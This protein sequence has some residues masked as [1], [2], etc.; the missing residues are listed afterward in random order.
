MLLK[1]S[2]II[3]NAERARFTGPSSTSPRKESTLEALSETASRQDADPASGADAG[4]RGRDWLLGQRSTPTDLGVGVL[5]G[6]LV[7]LLALLFR[8]EIVPTDPWHYIHSAMGFPNHSWVPLGYT[9][10]GMVL[11]A[12]PLVLAFGNAQVAYYFWPIVSAGVLAGS[13]YLLGRRWW[14]T[15]AGLLAVVLLVSNSIV[16]VNLSRGYPD[17]QSTAWVCAAMVAAL[18]AR[19]RLVEGGKLPV[20]ALLLVGFFLGWSFEA[21]ET[22]VLAWP[23]VAVVL[24]R[25]GTVLRAVSVVLLPLLLWVALDVGIGAIAYGDP[26]LKLH[27]FTHQ[28]L[29][30]T[31]NPADLKVLHQ[32]VG[33][34]RLSYLT[35]ILGIL[36]A[37]HP[38]AG[39]TFMLLLGGLAVVAVLVRN[40]PT[41][42][43]SLWFLSIY[44]LFVGIAGLFFP[45]HPAGRL[46]VQRYWV[47]FV[48]AAALA[49]AGLTVVVVRALL[50]RWPGLRVRPAMASAVVAVLVA[51]W[52]VV[53]A[54][55]Y[56]YGN[57]V[58]APFG[59]TA[60]QELR[61]HLGVAPVHDATVWSDWET[62]RLLPIYQRPAF[63]GAKVWTSS[64]KSLTAGSAPKRGD[65]VVLFSAHGST[66][67]FCRLALV[68][69][70]AKHPR[71]PSTWTLDFRSSAHNLMLYRVS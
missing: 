59:A 27:T 23:A 12:G 64:F 52:P 18:K 70:A 53:S 65:Y 41:R 34:P 5:V 62:L 63:G 3:E 21:R 50:R 71:P 13:V 29:A 26:L 48:P 55:R 58:F 8:T 54:V 66:C 16:F 10:Y 69:W 36:T 57:P 7:S 60:L 1:T 24:W 56:V 15:V 19:E 31:T 2:V 6:V 49:V 20:L 68:P 40:G 51:A 39:S 67:S 9:R 22:A 4:F 25:K 42:L 61:S 17:V 38:P 30:A 28:D 11:P 43:M 14:G 44:V 46:D 47:Q 33:R 32:F 45:L 35:V 37:A